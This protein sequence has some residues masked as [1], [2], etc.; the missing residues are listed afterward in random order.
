MGAH[1]FT[2]QSEQLL[3]LLLQKMMVVV[4]MSSMRMTR[5]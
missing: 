4:W 1:Q 2:G 5:G 3:L